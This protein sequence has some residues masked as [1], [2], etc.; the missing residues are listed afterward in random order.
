MQGPRAVVF[1]GTVLSQGQVH[2]A[3]LALAGDPQ[4]E[5]GVRRSA[6]PQEHLHLQR[7]LSLCEDCD[8]AFRGLIPPQWVR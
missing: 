4:Q 8:R 6:A 7:H 3:V 2:E 5:C 1:H